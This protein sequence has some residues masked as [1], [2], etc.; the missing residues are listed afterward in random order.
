MGVLKLINQPGVTKVGNPVFF[1]SRGESM[2]L[3]K[4]SLLVL[5]SERDGKHLIIG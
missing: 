1:H 2:T 5:K 3:L 4:W